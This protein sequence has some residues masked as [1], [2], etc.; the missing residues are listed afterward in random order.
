MILLDVVDIKKRFG[1]QPVLDGATFDLR[2]GDRAGLVGPN[3]CGKTTLLHI[4][5]GHDEP[6]SGDRRLHTTVHLGYLEQQPD[7]AP[8]RTLHDEARAALADL[9]LLQKEAEETAEEMARSTDPAEQKRLSARWDHLQHEL[10]RQDAYNIEHRIERVLDGLRFRRESYDQ[11]IASLSGG[12]QN[13]L[14]LAKLL[15]A[16]PNVMILDEPSNHLDIETTEWLEGFLLES[17]AA[18]I[19][20]S[21][22]RYFLDRVTNRTLELFGGTID[23]YTGNYSA[24]GR[25]KEERLLVQRRTYEKQRIEIEK[26]EEFIRRNFY[27]FP[28]RAEDRRKKLERIERVS[29]PRE[30]AEPSMSFPPAARSGDIVIR[31]E[32]MAKSFDRPLFKKVSLD[33]L[34]GQRWAVLGPNGSGKTTLLRCLLGLLPIDDGRVHLGQGV[35]PGYFDQ[36]LASLDD[37]LP[38]VDAIRAK[39]HRLNEHERRS[40][41]A[42]FGLTGDKA[43][44]PVSVLSGGERCRAALARLAVA[45]ANLLVLDEPTN[46]LDLWARAALEKALTG[47]DG[48]VLM[49]SHDRYFV[50]R[51]ADHLLIIEPDRVRVVEGNYDTYQMMLDRS[52]AD[53]ESKADQT[54]TSAS[55]KNKE[56]ASKPTRKRRFPFR[57]VEDL[58]AEIA[59]FE[60]LID[61][62]QS[63]LLDPAVLRDGQKV[64]QIKAET[65]QHRAKLDTLHEH[66]D[67]A[68]ELNW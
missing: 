52:A 3:G 15:L 4:L 48:S 66:W 37:D 59:E 58:E 39:Q 62:L 50:N 33:I 56:S 7:F 5:A 11:P 29:P 25:Q 2:P 34:R 40:L 6:D 60:S 46:H 65:D 8:G 1:P 38:V 67:E 51:V 12:E 35:V 53:G 10:H 16:E 22:D 43:M 27:S 20:V 63:K 55:S 42:R 44:Q 68:V 26:T 19:I 41:L 30:I 28:A 45:E 24:Y 36:Q 54:A 23:T 32:G 57:K 14:M 9:V 13:R 18:M 49:V 61:R 47:F 64:R 17:S 31:A 21:H